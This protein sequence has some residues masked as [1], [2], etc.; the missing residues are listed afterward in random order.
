MNS[1][2]DLAN[3]GLDDEENEQVHPECM[4]DTLEAPLAKRVKA[5]SSSSKSTVDQH[6]AETAP[7]PPPVTQIQNLHLCQDEPHIMRAVQSWSPDAI[8]MVVALHRASQPRRGTPGVSWV[9]LLSG[10]KSG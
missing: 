8:D 10:T 3:A 6:V 7:L 1:D 5:K 9:I 4:L 2:D